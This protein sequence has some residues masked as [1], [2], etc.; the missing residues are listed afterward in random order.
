MV[1]VGFAREV[2]QADTHEVCLTVCLTLSTHIAA[3]LIIPQRTRDAGRV[4]LDRWSLCN[5]REAL[6]CTVTV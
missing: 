6:L 4:A 2:I 3:S 1:I 5:Q